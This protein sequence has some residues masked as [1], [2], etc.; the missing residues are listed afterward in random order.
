MDLAARNLCSGRLARS[1]WD[2][3]GLRHGSGKRVRS[4][5]Q[6]TTRRRRPETLLGADYDEYIQ[7]SWDPTIG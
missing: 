1:G 2:T 6:N 3:G 7:H 4:S 5:A